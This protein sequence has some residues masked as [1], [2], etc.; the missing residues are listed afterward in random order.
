MLLINCCGIG[1]TAV[2][3]VHFELRHNYHVE[4]LHPEICA[5][6]ASAT[7]HSPHF[8]TLYGLRFSNKLKQIQTI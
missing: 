4:R 8:C 7:K 5:D 2:I 6:N 1:S 3:V